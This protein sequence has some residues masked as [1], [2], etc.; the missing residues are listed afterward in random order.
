MKD[1]LYDYLLILGDNPLILGHRLSE[2]CGHGPTLETDIALTNL[3]LDL[4]G[5]VRSLFQ[6][7]AAVKGGN[8]TEDSVAFLRSERGYKNAILL[9]QPNIDFA[10]VMVRQFLYDAF[11]LPQLEQLVKSKDKTIA[12]ISAKSIKE[13]RYHFRFSSQWIRRLGGGTEESHRRVTNAINVLYPFADELFNETMAEQ[14]MKEV[15]IGADLAK[16]KPI[17]VN[18]INE[19]FNEVGLKVADIAPRIAKG[20]EGLHSE[21]LGHILAELQYMQR[22]YPNMQW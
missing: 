10:H 12:A 15:G 19:T 4:F 18:E 5:Q 6:Y 11:N 1:T 17:F 3:S 7:A 2:L 20:K 9:E 8:A 16:I 14:K 22:A 13:C 21:Q